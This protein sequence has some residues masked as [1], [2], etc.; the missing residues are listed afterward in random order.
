MAR[1][2]FGFLAKN[3]PV[4]RFMKTNNIPGANWLKK[5]VVNALASDDCW[6]QHVQSGRGLCWNYVTLTNSI[7][8]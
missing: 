4:Q 7:A 2:F 3:K 5:R 6:S 8:L 1:N